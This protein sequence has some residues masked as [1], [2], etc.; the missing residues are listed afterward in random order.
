MQI[1]ITKEKHLSFKVFAFQLPRSANHPL[2]LTTTTSLPIMKRTP[3]ARFPYS[4]VFPSF[5]C[6][7][8]RGIPYQDQQKERQPGR[9]EQKRRRK[10]ENGQVKS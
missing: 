3:N 4:F 10:E 8:R 2:T 7:Q 5:L 1:Y 6:T 9:D